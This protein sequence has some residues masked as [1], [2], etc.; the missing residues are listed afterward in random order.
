M[1]WREV[2]HD[3]RGLVT[4]YV[5]HSSKTKAAA[6]LAHD[7]KTIRGWLAG[8]VPFAASDVALLINHALKDGIDLRPFQ[9]FAPLY[10]FSPML[11]YEAKAQKEPPDFS[12]L[13]T[14]EPPPV[15]KTDFCGLKLDSPL[16]LSSSP[17]LGDDKWASLMLGLGYV[18]L[19]TFKTRRTGEKQS[20]DPPQ[21]AFL[22]ERPDLINYNP[23]H[24]PEVLVTFDRDKIGTSI[25]DLVN[26]I[27]VPS[28]GPGRWQEVYERIKRHPRGRFI[29][30][31][32]M[33]DG[34]NRKDV[35]A[36]FESAVRTA[37]DVRP[38][39]VELNPSCPNLEKDKDL[40]AIPSVL[41]EICEKA[42][43]ILTGTGILL[44]VKLPHLSR[45]EMRKVLSEIGSLVDAVAYRNTLKVRPLARH[46]NGTTYPAFPGREFGGLSGPCT[47]ELTLK[48][49]TNLVD[50]REELGQD[51]RIIGIGGVCTP[52]DVVAL[53]DAGAD[54][55]QA[56]TAPMFDPLFAWKTRYHLERFEPDTST[57]PAIALT[58]PRDQIERDS[59]RNAYYAVSQIQRRFPNEPV[60][61][62][63]FC[64][65]WNGWMAQ[66]PVVPEASAR[67]MVPRTV[68]QWLRDLT[69]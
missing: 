67:R 31:S 23:Q 61:W 47:F 21:I 34:N 14:V 52:S 25:F 44:V 15:I 24:P 63:K 55:V 64:G 18:G 37:R 16:G 26:S 68:S 36:D 6:H 35:V 7:K 56:T 46:Q 65:I 38:P 28:E 43:Q 49:V 69:S 27:G 12:W 48:G 60:P 58:T 20:W 45:V 53:R 22:M 57:Q 62:E 2:I 29:G 4:H 17:L 11:T 13:T 3:F 1:H 50:V 30:I 59:Q 41:R 9:T 8:A 42:R 66:R 33:G 39:F 51:F 10:D 5:D 54:V 19:S 32:V 40:C